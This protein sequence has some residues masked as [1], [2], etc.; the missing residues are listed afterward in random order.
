MPV[1]SVIIG[2]R[3]RKDLGDIEGLAK[4]MAEFLLHPIVVTSDRRLVAGFRRLK[5]AG[6]LGWTEIPVRI[7][8]MDDVVRGE[9]AEN[10]DRKDFLPSELWAISQELKRREADHA[11]QRQGART[12]IVSNYHD[13]DFGRTRD[14]TAKALGISGSNLDKIDYVMQASETDPE[15]FGKYVE[16]MDST[17]NV[18]R[19][20]KQVQGQRNLDDLRNRK[21]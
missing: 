11:K 16:D 19:A 15:R 3:F 21:I 12:D 14:K 2:E 13:V 4:S 18:D 7:V 6:F 10:K 1:A 5:A 17:G 9:F 20:F 8:D